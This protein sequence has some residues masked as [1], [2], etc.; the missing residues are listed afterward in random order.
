MKYEQEQIKSNMSPA[1]PTGF[2]IRTSISNLMLA[3]TIVA[4]Q[5]I[6][7]SDSFVLDHPVYGEL[8]SATL[9]LD[10][11]YSSGVLTM[12]V[13]MPVT[14]SGGDTILFTTTF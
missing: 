7:A 8:D 11:G 1:D 10:G 6:I 5:K 2:D 3:G 13:T 9:K 4:T 14:F 12:P